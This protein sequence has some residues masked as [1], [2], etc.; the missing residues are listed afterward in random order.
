ME[1]AVVDSAK[2]CFCR[3]GLQYRQA[4]AFNAQQDRALEDYLEACVMLQY[5]TDK[6]V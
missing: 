1:D 6:R 5:N 3:K 2:F 4:N